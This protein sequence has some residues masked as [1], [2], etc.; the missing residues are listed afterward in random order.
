VPLVEMEESRHLRHTLGAPRLFNSPRLFA[1]ARDPWTVFAYWDADWPSVFK[2]TAPF[3]RQ[4]HLRIH[5]ADGLDEKEVAVEPMAGMCY[6]AM[7]QQHRECRLEIGYYRPADVWHSVATSNEVVIP[8]S[9]IAGTEDVDVATIPFHLTFQQLVELYGAKE[10]ALAVVISRAQ[11]RAVNRARSGK[12][13]RDERKIAR[14]TGIALSEIADARQ[15][16]HRVDLEKLRKQDQTLLPSGVTSP[17][18]GFRANR[19]ASG[20]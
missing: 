11:T 4:I 20:S 1:V 14:A 5:C 15:A 19:S 12:L 2:N 13:S 18:Q 3:D 7:S 16:F 9:K 6:V 17:S 8:S 10:E